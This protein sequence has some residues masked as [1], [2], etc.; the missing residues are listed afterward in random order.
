MT[1][2]TTT[3]AVQNN[4]FTNK[5]Y[6]STLKKDIVKIPH[7]QSIVKKQAIK[8]LFNS[9]ISEEDSGGD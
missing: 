2:G 1:Y 7:N 5:E 8:H 9:L 6:C 3:N 4:T